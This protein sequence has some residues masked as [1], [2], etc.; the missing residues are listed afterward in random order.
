MVWFYSFL[1]QADE[2]EE[3]LIYIHH[4]AKFAILFDAGAEA[5][6]LAHYPS[7]SGGHWVPMKSADFC[8]DILI[9]A[10]A[11]SNN[12]TAFFFLSW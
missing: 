3:G 6:L 5:F 2:E 1:C 4:Q 9:M 12:C 11:W 10:Y 7:H 8:I